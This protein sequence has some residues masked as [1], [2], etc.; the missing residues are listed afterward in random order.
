MPPASPTARCSPSCLAARLAGQLAAI[1]PV[2]G[3]MPVP[4][5]A[6][7]HPRRPVSVLLIHGTAD[8]IV[9]YDGGHVNGRGRGGDVRSVA[10]TY[11]RWRAIDHCPGR[12]VTTWLPVR[13]SDGTKV[14]RTASPGCAA[15]TSTVLYTVRGGGHTWP[16]GLQYL[17]VALVGRTT[18]QLDASQVILRFFAGLR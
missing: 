14:S 2:A 6:T 1:A 17:P 15:A 13:R 5:D 16:G 9:P 7:C 11:R 18:R 8:P 10:W 4:A 12:P 3:P